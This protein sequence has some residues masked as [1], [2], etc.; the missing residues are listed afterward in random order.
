MD[1]NVPGSEDYQKAIKENAAKGS[2]EGEKSIKIKFSPSLKAKLKETRGYYR[3]L[4]LFSALTAAMGES[5]DNTIHKAIGAVDS[6]KGDLL[7]DA[8]LFRQLLR[9]VS[10]DLRFVQ[11]F[12][13]RFLFV[14]PRAI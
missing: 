9:N 10:Y 3:G 1:A 7:V 5:V 13:S 4:E 6:S 8:P 11:A 2:P 12:T 14:V